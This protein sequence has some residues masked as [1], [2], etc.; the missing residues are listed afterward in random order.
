VD[1]FISTTSTTVSGGALQ[2]KSNVVFT[3]TNAQSDGSFVMVH[4]MGGRANIPG[5]EQPCY[6]RV[7]GAFKVTLR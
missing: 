4:H 5:Q 3:F 7:P 1:I 6:C 2:R